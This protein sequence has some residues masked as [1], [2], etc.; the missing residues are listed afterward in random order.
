MTFSSIGSVFL[1]I[2][3][4]SCQQIEEQ[5]S[6]NPYL[7]IIQF[8][9]LGGS[10]PDSPF[11]KKYTYYDHSDLPQRWVEVDSSGSIILDY[12]YEYDDHGSLTSALYKE[13]D[14]KEYGIERFSYP[15]DTIKITEWLD[16]T[17]QVYYTMVDHL[18]ENGNTY[19]A[20]F[21]DGK[22]IHGYDSTFYTDQGFQQRIFFT[23]LKG[24]VY[25]SRSFTYDSISPSGIW[26]KRKLW[27]SD[28]INEIQLK[29]FID[30]YSGSPDSLIQV[31]K[32]W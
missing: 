17:A 4:Y 5:N 7:E 26:I 29:N 13:G 24:I 11:K 27:R 14:Q 2:L 12:I 10:V 30:P 23:N 16:S 9:N 3:L 19:R 32:E 28:T 25:N 18:N 15:N 31:I 21:S 1:L 6:N 20:S 22:E 8:Y